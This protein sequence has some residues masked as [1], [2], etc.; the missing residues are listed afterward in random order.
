[1]RSQLRLDP[2]TGRWVVV[3]TDRL[4]RPASFAPRSLTVQAD[5]DRPCPFCPGNEET[6]LPTLETYGP[7]G[8]WLVRVVANLYPAFDGSDPMVV[9][10]KGPVFSEA[11]ASGIHEV[12]VLSPN[13]G[14]SWAD[15][16]EHQV[17]LVMQAIRDRIDAHEHTP[18][19]RYSQAIV[20]SGREAGA[21][22]EHPHGQLLGMPFVP[23]ELVDEQS[24]FVRF[25]GGCLLCATVDAELDMGHRVVEVT[26]ET[27]VLCPFWSGVP[28]EML[29][30]PRRHGPHLHHSAASDVNAVG[31]AVRTGVSLLRDRLGDVAYNLVF[32]S[33]PYRASSTYHWHVHIWPKLTTLAGFELG[34]G[35]FIN[36]VAPEQAAEELR[37]WVPAHH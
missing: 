33:A 14:E 13:H 36:I 16:S 24:G 15:L 11:P 8:S 2:L 17:H 35:V 32:H 22:I 4:T 6:S 28:F 27:A 30:V 1:M 10:T 37:A 19:L 21:S 18:G 7:S 31:E 9:T 5:H 25:A 20:N 23:R 34:T 26:D 12:L 3:S 29:V